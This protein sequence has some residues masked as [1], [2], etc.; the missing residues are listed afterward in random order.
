M[1]TLLNR[2]TGNGAVGT[3]YAA[4]AFFGF[5][6]GTAGFAIVIPLAGIRGHDLGFPVTTLGAGN[7]GLQDDCFTHCHI[8]TW[9]A[10]DL[11][12]KNY[13]PDSRK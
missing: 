12:F 9:G 11:F 8:L 5:E 13:I 3:E 1:I 4:V 7:V 2:R 10:S 6:Q